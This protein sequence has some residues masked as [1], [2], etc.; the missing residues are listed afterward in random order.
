MNKVGWHTSV[1]FL[2]KQNNSYF[3]D[4][5]TFQVF[6]GSP[7]TLKIPSFEELRLL[8]RLHPEI[9]IV[10]HTPYVVS[11]CKNPAEPIT[12]ATM[13]Y[14][15]EMARQLDISNVKYMVSHIGGI[16]SKETI[17]RGAV[18]IYDFCLKWLQATEGTRTILCLE[19][20]CGSKA[21]TKMGYA[22]ILAAI[23]K[24]INNPRIRMCLDT[25]HAY[26]A[27]FELSIDNLNKLK[28]YVSVIHFNAI[29]SYIEFGCHLDRH[30]ITSLDESKEDMYKVYKLLF[31]NEI[32]FIYEV[33]GEPYITRNNKWLQNKIKE[34]GYT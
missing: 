15:I 28:P 11:L 23:V 24:K 30:S 7:R 1:K 21:G 31:N 3:V 18:Y 19:N 27:G 26:S 16:S 8:K 33:E 9:D 2:L 14:Y 4:N 12:A 29:P 10:V 17:K 20:D 32:P 25:N 22:K 13:R 6:I 34:D 5:K